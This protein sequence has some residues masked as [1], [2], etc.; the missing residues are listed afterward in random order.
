MIE[1]IRGNIAFRLCCEFL[2]DQSDSEEARESKWKTVLHEAHT[3]FEDANQQ[4][5]DLQIDTLLVEFKFPD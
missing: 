5:W 3:I 4:D 1:T 2:I